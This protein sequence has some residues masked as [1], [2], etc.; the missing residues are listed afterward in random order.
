MV[1]KANRPP[2]GGRFHSG[3]ARSD[4]VFQRLAGL[5]LG[6]LR[7]GD[8]DRL[9]GTRVPPFAGGTL[10]DDKGSEAYEPNFGSLLQRGSDGI[11]YAIDRFGCIAL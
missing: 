2:C 5:E 7:S 3:G 11:E 1:P 4:G 10:C 9:I 6:L 8:I